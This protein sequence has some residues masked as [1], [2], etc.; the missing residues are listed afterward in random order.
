MLLIRWFS[1]EIKTL[2]AIFPV[3]TSSNR[4]ALIATG[5]GVGEEVCVLEFA[6]PNDDSDINRRQIESVPAD[7]VIIPFPLC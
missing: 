1:T 6:A 5:S 7:F 3:F 4:P 2:F